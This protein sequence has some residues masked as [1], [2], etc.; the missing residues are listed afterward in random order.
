[1][2]LHHFHEWLSHDFKRELEM[3]EYFGAFGKKGTL[4]SKVEPTNPKFGYVRDVANASKHV[5]YSQS[6]PSTGVKSITHVHITDRPY[7]TGNFCQGR[8]GGPNALIEDN[9]KQI[10]FDEC[11]SELYDYWK[12]LLERLTGKIYS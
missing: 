12:A 4:W 2:S 10:Y 8:F 5:K 9:G 11:A 7:D 1:M 3:D 6:K